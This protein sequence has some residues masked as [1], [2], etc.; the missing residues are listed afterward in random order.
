MA[1]DAQSQEMPHRLSA[2]SNGRTS[3]EDGLTEV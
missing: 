3:E 1:L 2:A